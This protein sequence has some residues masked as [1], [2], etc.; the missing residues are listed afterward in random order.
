MAKAYAGGLPLDLPE[1]S[2]LFAAIPPGFPPALISTGTRDLLL[3][4]CARL[5]ARLRHAGVPVDMRV[6]EG[7]WHVFE[8]YPELPEALDSLQG[9]ATFLRQ[10]L[11]RARVCGYPLSGTNTA[12]QRKPRQ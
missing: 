8:Y 1:I 11:D 4:D 10:H 2:P 9:I 7:M 6:A 12:E 3:S 5:A